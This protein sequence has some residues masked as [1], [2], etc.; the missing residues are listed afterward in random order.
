MAFT[1]NAIVLTQHLDAA[2]KRIKREIDKAVAGGLS[3]AFQ[4]VGI[5][6]GKVQF[7][8]KTD[9]S[10]AVV[11]EFDLPEELY[12]DQAET[13]IVDKFTW[14]AATYPGSTNPN[15]NGKAVLV[16]GV[17]GD[18]ATNPTVKYSFV[19]LTKL[20][21]IYT[22]GD[23]SININGYTVTVKISVAADNLLEVKADGLYVGSDD[24][25]LDKVPAAV[26][27]HFAMWSASGVL[28]D[29]GYGVATDAD[30]AAMLAENFGEEEGDEE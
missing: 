2:E 25:K 7:Y 6:N 13:T 26:S 8:A 12:L 4:S 14:S 16:L 22:A 21:D 24:S 28:I 19:N 5:A 11:G 15:L 17:K 10:G 20:I 3:H 9:K 18:R 1:P 30:I 29:S 27:G 23:S